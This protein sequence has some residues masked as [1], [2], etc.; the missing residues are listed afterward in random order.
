MNIGQYAPWMIPTNRRLIKSPVNPLDK[1]TIISIYPKEIDEKK[2]SIQPGE[3]HLDSGSYDKPT[4]LIVGPSSWWKEVDEQQPLLEITNSSIQIADSVVK[5]YVGSLLGVIIPE[6]MPGLFYI[7]GVISVDQLKKDYR[8]RLDNALKAQRNWY[9]E[10]VK[11]ADVMW[12]RTNGNPLTI[13]D[14][15]RLA[16]QEL[17]MKDKPWLKDFQTMELVPCPSCG[18]LRNNSYPVCAICKT[19]IDKAK[20]ESLGLKFA[21]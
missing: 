9:M 5:D 17:G 11:L 4:I 10:L 2:V 16:A 12:S 3:F 20:F 1:C 15:M 14:D 13:S 6:V 21:S 18:T 7:P 8:P 19:V